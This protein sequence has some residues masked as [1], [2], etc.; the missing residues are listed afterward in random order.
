MDAKELEDHLGK[1]H[2]KFAIP[3]GKRNMTE[4]DESSEAQSKRCNV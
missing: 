4:A 1:Q 3:E 2:V